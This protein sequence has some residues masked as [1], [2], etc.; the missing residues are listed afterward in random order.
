MLGGYLHILG[1][2]SFQ[3]CSVADIA[4]PD[5]FVKKYQRKETLKTVTTGEE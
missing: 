3:S 2:P 1:A 4:N 5:L